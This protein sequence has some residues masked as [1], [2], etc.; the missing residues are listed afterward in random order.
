MTIYG[1]AI[2]NEDMHIIAGYMVDEIRENM[3]THF[4]TNEDFLR[5]YIKR[6]PD[7]LPILQNEF[8]FK[9]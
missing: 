1:R 8:D 2:T 4:D 5:E 9:E 7:I 6:D 3:H